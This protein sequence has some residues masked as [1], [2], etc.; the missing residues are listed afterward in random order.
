MF[1]TNSLIVSLDIGTH[2]TLSLVGQVT[3]EGVEILGAGAVLSTGVERGLITNR[4]LAVQAIRKAVSEAEVGASCEI[5]SVC[6][7]ISGGHLQAFDSLGIAVIQA[8]EV[9]SADVEQAV[10]VAR[11]VALPADAQ[12]LHVLP[13]EFSVDG[14]GRG[15]NPVGTAGVRLET[16]VHIIT[17][18]SSAI[19]AVTTCCERADLQL[20][21]LYFD[22]LAAA[23]AVLTPEEKELG[24]ILLDMGAGTTSAVVFSQGSVQHS[25]VLPLGGQNISRDLAAGLDLPLADAEKIKQR[26]GCADASLLSQDETV[27]LP[28]IAGR[29]SIRVPRRRLGNL[30]EPRAEELFTVMQEHLASVDLGGDLRSGVVLTGGGAVMEGMGELAQRLFRVPVRRGFPRHLTGLVE[31][32]NSP[33]Y[34]TGVGLILC[35]LQQTQPNGVIPGTARRSVAAD[36]GTNGLDGCEIF[37]KGESRKQVQDEGVEGGG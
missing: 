31:E 37:F 22:A 34:A 2:Q 29:E 15:L 32:V 4:D 13:Q 5:H 27:E 20:G 6:A 16:R 11:A 28:P 23:E 36:A 1:N 3:P 18:A 25:A 7:G 12:I 21:G 14:Q 9:S 30:I 19:E 35:G 17:A 26:Y 24:V 33:V 8:D 10:E